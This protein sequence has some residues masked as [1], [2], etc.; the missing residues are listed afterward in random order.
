MFFCLMPNHVHIV[1]VPSDADG[2]W[3]AFRRLHREHTG[4]INTRMR[5]TGHL[6]QGRYGLVAMVE[7]HFVAALRYVDFNPVQARLVARAEDRPSTNPGQ[8]WVKAE[9]PTCASQRVP[10]DRDSK[11]SQNYG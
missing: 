9:T 3:R 6:W 5:T 10:I 7:E 4:F 11:A 8:A 2:L 1:I